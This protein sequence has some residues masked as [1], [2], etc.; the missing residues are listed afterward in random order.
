M[1]STRK[2]QIL[3]KLLISST[4]A[5]T[6]TAVHSQ[7]IAPSGSAADSLATVRVQGG[8]S[9]IPTSS[10]DDICE[11]RL[12]KAMDA[13]EKAEKALGF[14]QDEIAARARLDALKDQIIAVKD[15]I[16]QQ[17]DV[18]I[19]RLSKNDTGFKA[20]LISLLKTAERIALVALGVYLGSR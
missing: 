3:M 5:L 19:K 13:L 2:R 14:A 1:R 10:V 12:L 20:R 9:T 7:V 11:Q 4:L 6:G 16:I 8:D 18:L 17:Q 15:I